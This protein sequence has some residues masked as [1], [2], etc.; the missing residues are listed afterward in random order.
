M[1]P[2]P[3]SPEHPRG[4][5]NL[6]RALAV[7]RELLREDK[8]VCTPGWVLNRFNSSVT[9]GL[10]SWRRLNVPA[11]SCPRSRSHREHPPGRMD[12]NGPGTERIGQ[13]GRCCAQNAAFCAGRGCGVTGEEGQQEVRG[14]LGPVESRGFGCPP[15]RGWSIDSPSAALWDPHIPWGDEFCGWIHPQNHPKGADVPKLRVR[16]GRAGETL[17][18][19]RYPSGDSSLNWAQN[20]AGITGQNSRTC[21]FW[22]PFCMVQWDK[23]PEP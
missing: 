13:K 22:R 11:P 18:I 17:S 3:R 5:R 2:L 16:G 9:Q 6:Y 4:C 7:P 15:R 10:G 12:G 19:L 14:V 1:S 8:L 20:Q 21:F 23:K